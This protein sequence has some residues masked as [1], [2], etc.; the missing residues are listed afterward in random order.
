M[1]NLNRIEQNNAELRECIEIAESLPDMPKTIE[2]K[3]I[4]FID[5]DGTLL[6]SYT[7]E[8]VLALTE[9]PSHE[10]TDELLTFNG[11]NW[12]LEELKEEINL[13][14]L[15]FMQRHKIAVGATYQTV[16]NATYLFIDIDSD[17]EEHRKVIIS[18]C[19]SSRTSVTVDWGDGS[20]PSIITSTSSYADRLFQTSPHTYQK[21]S[22]IIKISSEH[23][24]YLGDNLL[25]DWSANSP[26]CIASAL[27]KVYLGSNL[28]GFWQET[29]FQCNN[30]SKISFSNT[31]SWGTKEDTPFVSCSSL[32]A[33][34]LGR[35]T[36]WITRYF[37][38]QCNGLEIVSL[39]GNFSSIEGYSAEVPFPAH[40]SIRILHVPLKATI[41]VTSFAGLGY[42]SAVMRLTSGQT[43]A[44]GYVTNQT[45]LKQV[46]IIGDAL[47]I[48]NNCFATDGKLEKVYLPSDIQSLGEYCFKENYSLSR[49]ELPETV[50]SIGSGCF[51]YCRTLTTLKIP[52]AVTTIGS[53]TFYNCTALKS[54]DIPDG[55]TSI[56]SSAFYNCSSLTSVV[57]PSAVATLGGS[58]FYGCSRLANISIPSGLTKINTQT[59]YNCYLLEYVDLTAY[60]TDTAFPTLG[61]TNAFNNC[62]KNTASGTFEIRVPT[63]RKAELEAM[64]NWSTY[65]DKI[66]EV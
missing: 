45:N 37:I 10:S 50:T 61:S 33:L 25:R 47:S 11:W 13:I 29:F 5:Y 19:P 15:D 2:E 27:K 44:G 46:K 54:V 28:F 64:T 21:G 34:V 62:G 16:D 48:P 36:R 9:L 53:A 22:Y 55:V 40:N 38:Q 31:G 12:T 65:A 63:G 30:L 32:K 1:S 51:N 6:H 52:S 41:G 59:F 23:Q 20:E 14:G 60:G 26:L 24:Y 66:V 58:A 39:P 18:A 43:T 56:D 7:P 3:Q 8:E 35:A 49:I 57:I 4:I 42:E 17:Y